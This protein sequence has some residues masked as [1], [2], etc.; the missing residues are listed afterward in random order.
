[1]LVILFVLLLINFIV[2]A[3]RL[4]MQDIVQ[5]QIST[6][7]GKGLIKLEPAKLFGNK[8]EGYQPIQ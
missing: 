7:T 2:L 4:R 8:K 6:R 1:V 5:K 3:K